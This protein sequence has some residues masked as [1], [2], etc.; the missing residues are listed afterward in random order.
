MAAAASQLLLAKGSAREEPTLVHGKNGF[1]TALLVPTNVLLAFDAVA[2]R[3]GAIGPRRS[4]PSPAPWLEVEVDFCGDVGASL[5]LGKEER[6]SI[7][8]LTRDADQE[9]PVGAAPPSAPAFLP[10]RR[11]HPTWYL[12]FN[13]C[14]RLHDGPRGVRFQLDLGPVRGPQ[15]VGSHG[16]QH[17]APEFSLGSSSVRIGTLGERLVRVGPI[18]R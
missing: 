13:K 3:G 18:L 7:R 1:S 10:F 15:L 14:S 9:L 11:V 4:G 6:R 16:R 17:E 12:M 8:E 5:G 2:A